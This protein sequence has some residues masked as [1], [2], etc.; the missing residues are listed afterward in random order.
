MRNKAKQLWRE[1]VN[2]ALDEWLV[3]DGV[4]CV[5]HPPGWR[6]PADPLLTR[7]TNLNMVYLSIQDDRKGKAVFNC[8]TRYDWYVLRNEP[9][10]GACTVRD[11]TGK[12]SLL[13]LRG[14]PFIVNSNFEVI[15]RLLAPVGTETCRVLWN[16]VYRDPE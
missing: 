4:L 13:D 10:A 7:L 5:L 1:F 14:L 2:R 12:V 15:Q 16:N 11:D 3:P 8:T 6:L 9:S